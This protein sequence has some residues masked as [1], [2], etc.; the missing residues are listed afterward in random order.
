MSQDKVG[1]VSTV[2]GRG[3]SV[4]KRALSCDRRCTRDK[5][6]NRESRTSDNFFDARAIFLSFFSCGLWVS[7]L[8]ECYASALGFGRE[9]RDR[10]MCCDRE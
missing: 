8:L 4:R 2:A 3:Q 5:D 6:R 9:R 7:V 10:V 1:T